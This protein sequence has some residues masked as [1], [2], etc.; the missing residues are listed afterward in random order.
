MCV[1]GVAVIRSIDEGC[2]RDYL[3]CVR[4]DYDLATGPP[5][6]GAC[7]GTTMNWR[8]RIESLFLILLRPTGLKLSNENIFFV[9]TVRLTEN[10]AFLCL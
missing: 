6:V 4:E 10:F 1:T 9:T 3:G 8:G 2:T 5:H 7:R